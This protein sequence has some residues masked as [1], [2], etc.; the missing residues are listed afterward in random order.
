MNIPVQIYEMFCPKCGS[1]IE[2]SLFQASFYGFATYFEPESKSLVRIDLEGVHHKKTSVDKLLKK[3][4]QKKFPNR[5]DVEWIDLSKERIC[6]HCNT[7]FQSSEGINARFCFEG[8]IE[9]DTLP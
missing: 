5:T 1:R 7:R 6:G 4:T 3:Y 8:K 2:Y 9:A